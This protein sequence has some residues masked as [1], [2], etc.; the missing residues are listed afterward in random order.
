MNTAICV[1]AMVALAAAVWLTTAI[2]HD[3][4][5]WQ[6]RQQVITQF[7]DTLEQRLERHQPRVI[8][9]IAKNDAWNQPHALME[10]NGHFYST[11]SSSDVSDMEA[12]ADEAAAYFDRKQLMGWI[13]DD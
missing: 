5:I 3:R 6:E 1:G 7:Q 12:R 10:A 13:F 2:R 11:R 4:A 8:V 9:W